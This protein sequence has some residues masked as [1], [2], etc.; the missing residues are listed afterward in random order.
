MGAEQGYRGPL[1]RPLPELDAGAA[2]RSWR[3]ER[4]GWGLVTLIVVLA[5]VGVFGHGPASWTSTTS[6]QG[7]I[8]LD[9]QRVARH[10]ADE[11]V[12]LHLGTSTVRDGRIELEV[13]GDWVQAVRV[14][15]LVPEP[16]AQRSVPGGLLLE[17]EADA[18][19]PTV[20]TLYYRAFR[21]GSQEAEISAGG[22]RLGF[23]QWVLP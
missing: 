8:V 17:F 19:A 9:H 12:T 21:Y 2:E 15:S 14:D 20:V 1:A 7:G 4:L 22:D 16:S 10:N 11:Q 13:L 5:L 3:L 23:T 18:V 6:S